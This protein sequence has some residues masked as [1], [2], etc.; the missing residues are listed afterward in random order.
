MI[1][2]RLSLSD[3]FIKMQ[4]FLNKGR[5]RPSS[6]PSTFCDVLALEARSLDSLCAAEPRPSASHMQLPHRY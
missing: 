5:R 1:F 6:P 3:S 4:P 2:R